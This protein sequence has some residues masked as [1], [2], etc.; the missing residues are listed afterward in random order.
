MTQLLVLSPETHRLAGWQPPRDF[1]F[2]ARH[3][4]VSMSIHELTQV[5]PIY[6]MGF[7]KH[8]AS[9]LP[10]LVII[11]GLA[12]GQNLY[13]TPDGRWTAPYLPTGVRLYPF[14]M[15]PVSS[16]SRAY[17]LAFNLA[18]EAFREAPKPELGELRFFDDEG[19]PTSAVK[20]IIRDLQAEL[21]G[22]RLTRIAVAALHQHELLEPWPGAQ[23]DDTAGNNHVLFRI[24]EPKLNALDAA[25]L[26]DLQEKN[27]LPLA[28]AQ[29]FSINRV[30]I[31]KKLT[32]H[33]AQQKPT[34][35]TPPQPDP[36]IIEK[37]FDQAQSE[38]I[39]FNF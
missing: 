29:L 34:E 32:S 11:T 4:F 25:A 1:R 10:E 7:F 12:Q 27:A 21:N 2:L 31:L 36:S 38:T 22:K 37:V 6:P 24:N 39:K 30:E 35:T 28:Y 17:N 18:S 33:Y 14:V 19:Q 26:K 15:Q 13:V 23:S 20:T 8:T 3:Q 9:E 16:E 5:L